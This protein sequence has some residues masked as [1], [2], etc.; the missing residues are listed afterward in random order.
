MSQITVLDIAPI[1]G[2]QLTP[3]M[4]QRLHPEY[5]KMYDEVLAGK[6]QVHERPP[7][8]FRTS[9][10][11]YLCS[12]P[13]SLNG[14]DLC[15]QQGRGKLHSGSIASPACSAPARYRYSSQVHGPQGAEGQRESVLAPRRQTRQRP[16]PVFPPYPYVG[17]ILIK[18]EPMTK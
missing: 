16:A 7:R 5:V 4:R 3:E 14:S 8:T 11:A 13:P 2:G 12:R 6:A 15:L 18:T 10:I 17:C 1:S 9:V